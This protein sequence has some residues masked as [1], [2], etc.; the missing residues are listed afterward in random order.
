MP[1]AH[2]INFFKSAGPN[3]CPNT[4]YVDV[5]AHEC[6][7][8]VDDQLGGIVDG[9]Y[10]EGFGDALCQLI[11]RQEIVGRDFRKPGSPLRDA[12]LAPPFNPAAE[13]HQQGWSYSGFV[14]KTINGLKAKYHNDAIAYEVAKKILLTTAVQNPSSI[15]DAVRLSLVA[16]KSLFPAPGGTSLHRTILRDAA[17]AMSIPL[18]ALVEAAPVAEAVAA[19]EGNVLQGLLDFE[20]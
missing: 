19:P 7:H 4:A 17:T 18:P 1:G 8:A 16:D 12:K 20:N 14:F 5:I 3:S 13:V 15:P 10:S 6:G 2:T 11:T 9:G